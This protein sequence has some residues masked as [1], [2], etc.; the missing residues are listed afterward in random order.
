M[1]CLVLSYLALTLHIATFASWQRFT[2]WC[3]K[4]IPYEGES[5]MP[6]ERAKSIHMRELLGSNDKCII[7]IMHT[8]AFSR[9]M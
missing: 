1:A 8:A 2:Y 6:D 7:C 5:V 9:N 3:S 4:T